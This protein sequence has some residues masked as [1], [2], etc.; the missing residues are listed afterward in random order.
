MLLDLLTKRFVFEKFEEAGYIAIIPNVLGII[1]SE[2]EGIVF[3]LAQGNNR[4]FII[5]SF[6]AIATIFWFYHSFYKS[7]FST[8]IAFGLILSGAVGNLWDRL[9]YHHV[10]DFIDVH[11][12]RWYHWPTFNF[13]DSFIC[14]GVG[15]LV[16]E[17]LFRKEQKKTA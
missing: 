15:L 8:N 6:V 13:A 1:C 11:A 10:R 3:G 2:N 9:F 14:I 12:G 7:G 17:T 16:W 4:I 5:L